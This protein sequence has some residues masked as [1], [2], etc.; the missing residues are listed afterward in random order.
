M[1]TAAGTPW[2]DLLRDLVDDDARTGRAQRL[3]TTFT[4]C[5]MGLLGVVLMT[6]LT[7]A[8]VVYGMVGWVSVAGA[9]GLLGLLG[10]AR[11]AV[12]RRGRLGPNAT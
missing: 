11:W 9:G 2:T 1:S 7:V 12:R 10:I 5:A 3:A 6:A 4:W 8:V